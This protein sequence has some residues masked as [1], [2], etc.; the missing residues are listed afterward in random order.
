MALRGK[1]QLPLRL[2]P[3]KKFHGLFQVQFF[4]AIWYSPRSN[5]IPLFGPRTQGGPVK[6]WTVPFYE[7]E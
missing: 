1:F 5:N 7:V 3:A 2:I 6:V 4:V